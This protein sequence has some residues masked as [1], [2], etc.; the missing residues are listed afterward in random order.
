MS[1]GKLNVGILGC[2]DYL[3]WQIPGLKSSENVEVKKLFDPR[4]EMSGKYAKEL[5]GEA[6]SADDDIFNDDGI[7]IVMPFVPPWIR[8]VVVEK[9]VNAGKHILTTKPLAPSIEDCEAIAEMIGDK[10]RAGVMYG[11]TGSTEVETYKKIFSSGEYGKLALFKQDWIHHYPQWNDWALD[12]EKNGGPFMDAMIHNLNIAR[13]LMGR[14]ETALTFFSDKHAHPDL[15]CSD[16]DFLKLDFEGAGSA[17]LFITWAADLEVTSTEGNYREH[18]DNKFMVTDKGYYVTTE[19]EGIQVS[20][21]GDRKTIP[22]EKIDGTVFDRFADAVMN[23]TPNPSDVPTV[24][25]AVTDINI[26]RT[27][28]A[29]V[30]AKVSL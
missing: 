21:E 30:G 1:D 8:K 24:E 12:P 26:I 2:G 4:S 22:M 11:R 15:T 25:E 29:N 17:H 14:K 28:M 13:Y 27:G 7:D 5:G 18:H 9:A 16:T 6:V 23:D 20:K 10:V 19:K 3:R